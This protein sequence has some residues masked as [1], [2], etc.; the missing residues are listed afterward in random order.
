MNKKATVI[1]ASLFS[2]TV[3]AGSVAVIASASGVIHDNSMTTLAAKLDDFY[4]TR[5]SAVATTEPVI[6]EPVI[7]EPPAEPLDEEPPIVKIMMASSDDE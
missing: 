4:Y 3:V 7:E 5:T 6:E 1:V 2:L